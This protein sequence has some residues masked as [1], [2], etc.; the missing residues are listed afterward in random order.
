MS[1]EE[2][3]MTA[4]VECGEE[5]LDGDPRPC[6]CEHCGECVSYHEE[7]GSCGKCHESP[8]HELCDVCGECME[9]YHDVCYQCGICLEDYDH[10]SCDNCG[11]CSEEGDCNCWGTSSDPG[12]TERGEKVHLSSTNWEKVWPNAA[13]HRSIDPVVKAAEFYILEAISAGV[14][15]PVR[16][17]QAELVGKHAEDE[18]YSLFGDVRDELHD[19]IVN[20]NKRVAQ[21]RTVD[22][23][24]DLAYLMGAASYELD[25]LVDEMDAVLVDYVHLA[26][27]GE[28]RHMKAMKEGWFRMSQNRSTAWA[29]WHDIFDQ[30]GVEALSDIADLFLELDGGSYCGPPWANAA[31]ILRQRLEGTLGPDERINKRMFVDRVWSLEHNGGC[32]LDKLPWKCNNHHG[33]GVRQIKNVLDMHAAATPNFFGLLRACSIEVRELYEAYHAA[34]TKVM[35]D[36]GEEPPRSYLEPTEPRRM[37]KSCGTNGSFHL[38]GCHR[39][40]KHRFGMVDTTEGDLIPEEHWGDY[41]WTVWEMKPDDTP[42]WWDS[43][44]VLHVKEDTTVVVNV[45]DQSTLDTLVHESGSLKSL[46][47]ETFAI[48]DTDDKIM[49]RVDI[50]ATVLMS[51]QVTC[52]PNPG[53]KDYWMENPGI[54]TMTEI[55]AMASDGKSVWK[56]PALT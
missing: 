14:I 3:E 19:T 44:G 48:P 54:I 12:W 5:Y 38:A 42:A 39:V 24:F 34:A 22:P 20:R 27:G 4:C 26:C 10:M 29:Q 46:I 11:E 53:N 9:S 18:F 40:R 23:E 56:S 13:K 8:S 49:I 35:V 33:W 41:A 6:E 17:V 16:G 21:R 37:C 36:R 30:V 52:L 28:V 32:L 15:H 25:R 51:G 50:D 43:K 55:M 7:C 31:Q 2:D 45:I 1:D 47:G